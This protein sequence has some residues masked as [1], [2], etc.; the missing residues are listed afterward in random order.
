MAEQ[1]RTTVGI[2]GLGIIAETHLRVLAENG[3]YTLVFTADPNRAESVDFRGDRPPHYA[4]LAEAL[5]SHT[6]D[7]VVIATPTETHVGLAVQALS[8]SSAR[9]LVEKP[10]VHDLKALARLRELEGDNETDVGGRLFTAHHFAFSPEVEWAARLVGD[11]PEWGPVTGVTSAFYDPYV[12]RGQ[13]AFDSYVSSWMDS[14]VNQL[15][16]LARLVDLTALASGKETDGGASS[17]HTVAY[18]SRGRTGEARLLSGWLTGAS[19]KKTVLSFAD[20]GVDVWMDHTAMTGFAARGP[21]LLANHA[22]D[23]R[24]ARKLAHY[25]PLYASLASPVLDPVLTFA[26]AARITGIHHAVAGGPLSS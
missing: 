17:W 6:P 19:S 16:V 9:V 1:G 18:T 26:T 20:S 2:V 4:T 5:A 22:S 14:G 11:H 13:Q 10:L 23:G 21:A 3:H 12:L 15:S 25:R 8:G 24:T 7:L